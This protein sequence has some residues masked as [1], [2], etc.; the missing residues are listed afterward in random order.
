LIES[1]PSLKS[2]LPEAIGQAYGTAVI[3]AEAETD[4]AE[5]FF[6]AAC[7]WSFEQ[8]MDPDFWPQ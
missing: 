4:I 8:M 7:P 2:V 3:K 5:S 1:N 6:P